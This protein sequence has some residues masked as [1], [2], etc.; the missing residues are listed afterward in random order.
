ML[1]MDESTSNPIT[2]EN[3]AFLLLWGDHHRKKREN[4]HETHNISYFLEEKQLFS[5]CANRS[6]G[7]LFLP[8]PPLPYALRPEQGLR[9]R[10]GIMIS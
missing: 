9:S 6:V 2:F 7:S 3:D 1:T 4:G 8:C 5:L 10:L